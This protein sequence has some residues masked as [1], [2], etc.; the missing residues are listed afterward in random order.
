MNCHARLVTESSDAAA[1][2]LAL[3][4][5][6]AALK[7]LRVATRAEGGRVVS[8]IDAASVSTLLATVDDLLRCQMAAESVI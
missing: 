1:A 5:D 8:E 2:A 4:A 6:N 3:T 7:S